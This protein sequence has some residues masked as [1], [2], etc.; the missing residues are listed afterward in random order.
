[1][2][3]AKWKQFELWQLEECNL[4]IKA[5]EARHIQL[6]VRV[7]AKRKCLLKL[8]G[9]LKHDRIDDDG[10]SPLRRRTERGV[11]RDS[12]AIVSFKT[13]RRR[14]VQTS[15]QVMCDGCRRA[16]SAVQ[17]C[18]F[19]DSGQSHFKQEQFIRSGSW[20]M[21]GIERWESHECN[22]PRQ[23][24]TD[25]SV[26]KKC[27]AERTETTAVVDVDVRGRGLCLRVWT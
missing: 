12:C 21:G 26:H 4:R 7:G 23:L 5:W 13:V 3:A 24:Q 9:R 14:V 15:S 16:V 20:M 6:E 19:S 8:V 27:I 11:R 22:L 10:V 1:M 17:G 25:Y 2:N 18:W